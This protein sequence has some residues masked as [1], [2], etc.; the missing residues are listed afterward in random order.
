[1]FLDA[2]ESPMSKNKHQYEFIDAMCLAMFIYMRAIAQ[3][4]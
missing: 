2:F 4:R 3:T 1:M